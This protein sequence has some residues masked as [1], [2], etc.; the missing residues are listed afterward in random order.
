MVT[1]VH[2]A[3]RFGKLVG[4]GGKISEAELIGSGAAGIA[5]GGVGGRV[6]SAEG[7]GLPTEGVGDDVVGPSGIEAGVGVGIGIVI[8]IINGRGEDGDVGVD[9]EGDAFKGG[10]LESGSVGVD[11]GMVVRVG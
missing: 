6:K 8:E 5:E 9:R 11:V 7:A 10:V 2:R 4:R 3:V 1:D